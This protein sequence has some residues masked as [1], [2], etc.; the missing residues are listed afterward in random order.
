MGARVLG[1]LLAVDERAAVGHG[2]AEQRVEWRQAQD[3]VLARVACDLA[4]LVHRRPVHVQCVGVGYAKLEV[5]G[6]LVDGIAEV[7]FAH[8]HDVKLK[9]LLGDWVLGVSIVFSFTCY[10]L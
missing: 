10:I 6:K 9:A 3:V 1:Q 8:L 5:V 4:A 7:A 2:A